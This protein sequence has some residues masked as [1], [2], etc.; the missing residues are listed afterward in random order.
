V[1]TAGGVDTVER[2]ELGRLFAALTELEQRPRAVLDPGL[3]QAGR[4]LESRVVAAMSVAILEAR[5]AGFDWAEIAE[6]AGMSRQAAVHR[7]GALDRSLCGTR[8]GCGC[9]PGRAA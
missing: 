3:L 6:V 5:R 2:L 8:H 4:A 9:V 7:W 1:P